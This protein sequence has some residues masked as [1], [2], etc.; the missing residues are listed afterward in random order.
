MYRWIDVLKDWQTLVTGALAII[1]ALIGGTY[2]R[3][4]TTI[5]EKREQA[6]LKRQHAAARA[7]LPLALSALVDYAK[8]CASNLH[9]PMGSASGSGVL[10]RSYVPPTLDPGVIPQLR[11]VIESADELLGERVSTIIS[12]VQILAARLRSISDPNTL[13]TAHVRE[14]L[15][16]RAAVIY[17]RGEELFA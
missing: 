12:D 7:V 5:V 15:M 13:L 8:D 17:A 4:Q 1:A 11:D 16:L 9:P 3:Q 10:Q 2:I 14:S 6:R